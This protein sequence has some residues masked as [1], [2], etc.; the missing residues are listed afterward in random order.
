MP[1]F[2]DVASKHVAELMTICGGK[3]LST[4]LRGIFWMAARQLAAIKIEAPPDF[5]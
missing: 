4:Y 5:M 2:A 1:V 3:L